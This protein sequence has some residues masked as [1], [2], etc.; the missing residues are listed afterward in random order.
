MSK[1]AAVILLL[2]GIIVPEALGLWDTGYSPTANY[3]SEL[4]ALGSPTYNLANWLGFLP[5]GVVLIVLI[6]HLWRALPKNW[7]TRLGL[8]FMSGMV[9]GYL[10]AFF[11]PCD[12]GCPADG[13][14][15]Q[16]IHNLSG[17]L[18]YLMALIGLPLIAIG[19][20]KSAPRAAQ[21]TALAFLVVAASSVLMSVPEAQSYRGLSQRL[22]DYSI[23]LWFAALTFQG[24][25][26]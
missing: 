22:A 20:R 3:L 18:A 16:A 23:F 10:G 6:F 24:K 2:S 5:V 12:M 26:R 14:G 9:I 4:G 11:Y 15:R 19:T 7:P 8:I 13:V 1:I 25:L 21:L 17:V